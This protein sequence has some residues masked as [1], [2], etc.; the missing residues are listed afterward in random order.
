MS[1]D[2]P[3][4]LE[5][6]KDQ[7]YSGLDGE[8]NSLR[9]TYQ[10]DPYFKSRDAA[11]R[12][13][14]WKDSLVQRTHNPL[15]TQRPKGTPNLIITGGWFYDTLVADAQPEGLVIRSDSPLISVLESKYSDYLLRLSPLAL[16]YYV[17]ERLFTRLQEATNR[18]LTQ[19]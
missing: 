6:I 15:F 8:G 19:S 9:P 5:L 10:E 12:Y 3:L 13:S 1:E 18:W 14:D 7:L 2:E 4:L 17:T 16:E 11:Q